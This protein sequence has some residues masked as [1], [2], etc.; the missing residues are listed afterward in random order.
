MS[1]SMV[2]KVPVDN[3]YVATNGSDHNPGTLDKPFLTLEK[4]REAVREIKKSGSLP[5]GGLT[6][7]LRGGDYFRKSALDLSAEDSG[8]DTNPVV[9]RAWHTEKV[10]LLGGRVITG[11]LPLRDDEIKARLDVK[12]Q[13]HV[14]VADLRALGITDYGALSSRGFGRPVTAAHGELFFGGLPMT[15]ARWPNTGEWEHIAGFPKESGADDGHGTIIGSLKAGFNYAGDRP[16][17]WKNTENLWVHGFWAYDWANSYEKVAGL[18]LPN[19]FIQTEEPFGNY[20]FCSGQRFYFLNILDELDEPGEWYIDPTAGLLYFWPPSSIES[21]EVLF[22][23]LNEPFLRISEASNIAFEGIVF[24]AARGN[25]VEITNSTG[26]RIADCRICNTGNWGVLINGGNDNGVSSCEITDT[27]DGGVSLTGGDRQTLVPGNHFVENCHFQRQA[28]WSKCYSPAISM[29]GVGLRASHNLI[30]DHPHCAILFWGN[31]M[32][33]EYND[34]HHIALETGDVGAIYTGRDYTFRG[35]RILNNYIHETGGVGMGSMGVYM[36]D[37]VSGTQVMGNIFYKVHWAMFIGGGR[38]HRIENNLFV[39]CEPAVRADGRG[40]DT[41]PVWHNMVN[42]FMRGQMARVPLEL[43]RQRY[44]EMKT[45]DAY[46]GMPGGTPIEGEAFTGVPPEGNRIARNVC[47]G[48]WIDIAWLA[49]PKIFDIRDNFISNDHTL[50]GGYQNGFRIPPSSP[51]LKL[52][53]KPLKFSEIGIQSTANLSLNP[54]GSVNPFIGASTSTGKA[55]VYHGLGKTFPGAATPFGLVQVSPN[56][57]TGGDNGPGYSYEHQTIEGFAFTQMSGIGWYGDLGNFL[58]MP[59]CGPMKTNPGRESPEI[60]GYRSGYDKSSEKASAG[61]Y[62]VRLTDP[63]IRAEATASPHSGMLRFTFPANKRSR[64]Q[65]DLARRVGGTS[66]EQFIKVLDDNTIQG[67]MKCTADG[68]GWG[69]GGGKPDYTVYFYAQFSKPLTDFGVWSATIPEGTDRHREFEESA[70]FQRITAG[71][72]IAKGCREKQ[73]RHLGFYTDF[74]TLDGEEVVMKSGISFVSMDGAKENLETEIPGWDFDRI[75]EEAT[76]LWDQALSRISVEGGSEEERV[77]FYTA[78]YHT[79]IDPRAFAD[80]DGNY[81]GGDGKIHHTGDFTKRTIFSGWDVFRSQFP[82]QTII[83]PS[84]VNDMINSLVELADENGSKYLERWEFLNAYSGCMLGNPAVS[85]IVDAYA[86]GIRNFNIPKAYEYSRNSVEKF[87][88]GELGHSYGIS[89]TLEHAYSE[90][91]MAEFARYL[92]KSGDEAIYRKRA[93]SYRNIFDPSVGWFRPKNHDGSWEPWPQK[94]RLEQGYGSVE[95]NPYQ[96][97]W[98]VPQDVN[99]LAG[100]LGG[101]EKTIAD[102]TDFFEKSPENMMWNDY[103]NHPNEPVHQVP[104]MFNRLGA[105]WLTQKWTREICRRAYH[106]SVEGLVGNED[107]GQM[108]AWYVLAASGLHPVCPGDTRYEIT[109]PVFDKITFQ[110]DPA[111]ATG[112]SFTI[113]TRNNSPENRYI[114][115]A[116]LN[117]KPYRYCWIRHETIVAGGTLELEM[118]PAPNENWGEN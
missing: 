4:A 109:S 52:G 77:I 19:H 41:K 80:V 21:G 46:Y 56:T 50:I 116:R 101:R 91:C 110:L 118:G 100:L 117:G 69:N 30:H 96:Q 94:G 66:V 3:I 97:G 98:F 108:S 67:W 35:N 28:R 36:D 62:S 51:V 68:G 2:S 7:W 75:K 73:G 114:Q 13:D 39:D 88:N 64:I 53:F 22:S 102:L 58:V 60:Q 47:I 29:T 63:D 70:G 112:D 20:G 93:L 23:E 95:S 45:L 18:D 33:I 5:P 115:S 86:K 27:G 15:L 59:A 17:R 84:V 61:Y 74:P 26:I 25:A 90:W 37:C 82:L 40:L 43:Y 111:Y 87:G 72:E 38:D 55:G 85:V 14:M 79:M 107:V 104:F 34:I 105:P 9:W 65:I 89:S 44:P 24:E 76:K 54:S 49:D 1:G 31:D 92:S 6:I 113:I 103:Y 8:T 83:N 78:L 10:R 32:L 12:A 57:I 42:T 99:G 16:S 106:N 71:A 48:N 81:P 11:F